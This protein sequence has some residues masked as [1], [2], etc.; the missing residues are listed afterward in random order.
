M[1]V[2]KRSAIWM[3]TAWLTFALISSSCASAAPKGGANPDQSTAAPPQRTVVLAVRTEP[4]SLADRPFVS[5]TPVLDTVPL[6]NAEL[7]RKDERGQSFPFLAEALP[8]V[9]T[10]SWRVLAD[11]GME[12]TYRLKPNLTWHDGS[13]LT[14]DDFVFAWR[15]YAT[16]ALGQSKP[17]PIE[18]MED[19]TAVDSRTFTIRWK[20]IYADADQLY[21]DFPP[22]PKHILARDF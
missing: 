12:T 17:L 1:L 15:V 5:S 20:Q 8:K 22:L 16:P 18:P 13:A 2:Q 7:D 19:V 21:T 10:E 6:F 11:G 4:P 9:G 14:S 3:S